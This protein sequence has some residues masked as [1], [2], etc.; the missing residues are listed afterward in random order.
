MKTIIVKKEYQPEKVLNS[1]I[2]YRRYRKVNGKIQ[3]GRQPQ[4]QQMIHFCENL[5]ND[6]N[7]ELSELK[8]AQLKNI[9]TQYQRKLNG[10]IYRKFNVA[11]ENILNQYEEQ[12]KDYKFERNYQMSKTFNRFIRDCF[13]E[14]IVVTEKK[15]QISEVIT[16]YNNHNQEIPQWAA[17]SISYAL[18][19]CTQNLNK[20]KFSAGRCIKI[21]PELAKDFLKQAVE[22]FNLTNTEINKVTIIKEDNKYFARYKNEEKQLTITL[23]EQYEENTLPLENS[24][25]SIDQSSN[26]QSN[27]Q[28]TTDFSIEELI[29]MLKNKGAKE[30][31]LKF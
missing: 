14:K 4:V 24:I 31:I 10:Q 1:Q 30:I 3:R 28:L 5:F 20:L 16:Y 22:L 2:N 13:N 17:M 21:K 6:G 8:I 11:F 23:E 18:N 12:L 29:N 26:L 25:Y 15:P 27:T 9:I 19:H 7:Y